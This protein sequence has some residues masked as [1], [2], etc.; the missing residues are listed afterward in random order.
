VNEEVNVIVLTEGHW[1]GELNFCHKQTGAPVPVFANVFPILDRQTGQ[2]I[3]MATVTRDMTDYRKIEE[4]R[5]RLSQEIEQAIALKDQSA[6]ATSLS[7]YSKGELLRLAKD[8][9]VSAK[10]REVALQRWLALDNREREDSMK[11]VK[12]LIESAR[13]RL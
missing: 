12:S 13:Q 4:S 7:S 3:A 9:Q 10:V 8:K 2:P 5:R 6:I 11:R 1:D